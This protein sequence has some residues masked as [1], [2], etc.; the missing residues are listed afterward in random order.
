MHPAPQ[1]LLADT[2][3]IFRQGIMAILQQSHP[4]AVFGHASSFQEANAKIRCQP[5]HLIICDMHLSD[6][7]GFELIQEARRLPVPIPILV[8]TAN[9]I[10]IYGRGAVK[11]GAAAYLPKDTP[12]EELLAATDLL[13]VGQRYINRHLALALADATDENSE[14]PLH[15]TLSHREMQVLVL[16]AEGK[17]LKRI[18]AQ[19]SLS[20]KTVSTYRSRVTD[21]LKVRSDAELVKYCL[22]HH[23]IPPLTDPMPHGSDA[24]HGGM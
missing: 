10:H 15:E 1:I 5:W 18:A 3:P 8:L 11:S 6:R 19:L 12:S 9:P 16:L 22:K 4:E 24:P 21:K 17:S 13:L 7:N 2:Q 20:P 14:K 23:L